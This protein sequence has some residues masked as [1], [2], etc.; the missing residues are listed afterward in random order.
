M[1]LAVFCPSLI[2]SGWR[3][4]AGTVVSYPLCQCMA[5]DGLLSGWVRVLHSRKYGIVLLL[6]SCSK[7]HL[8]SSLA[9]IVVKLFLWGWEVSFAWGIFFCLYGGQNLAFQERLSSLK[10]YGRLSLHF[11]Q[12]SVPEQCCGFLKPPSMPYVH[13]CKSKLHLL[14]EIRWNGDIRILGLIFYYY[15]LNNNWDF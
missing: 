4:F 14:C 9:V 12:Q 2:S 8:L 13:T 7:V 10:S 1:C 11:F 5:H 6:S 3:F 15:I